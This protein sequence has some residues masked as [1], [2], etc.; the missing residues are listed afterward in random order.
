MKRRKRRAVRI[1]FRRSSPLVKA[2]ILVTVVLST[3]TLVALRAGI[4]NQRSQY[5]AMRLQAAM[6]VESNA[7]LHE[8]LGDMDSVDSVILIAMEELGLVLPDSTIFDPQE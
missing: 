5:E 6:L 4:E 8:R 1:R 2:V 3:I 7:M